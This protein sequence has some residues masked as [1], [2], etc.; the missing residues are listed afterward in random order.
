M[1]RQGRPG[2]RGKFVQ[3]EPRLSQTAAC[4]DEWLPIKPGTEGLLALAMA[5]VIVN[6]QLHD[7]DFVAQSTDRI[8]G[9]VGA[10][11]NY[12][13][14]DDRGADRRAG[15]KHRSASRASSPTPSQRGRGRQPRRRLA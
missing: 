9:M 15:R 13:P 10:L 1:F 4:A 7:K 3:A 2:I 5:H 14:A 11:A 6:E 12:A 8:C